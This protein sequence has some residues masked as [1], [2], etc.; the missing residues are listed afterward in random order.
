MGYVGC[1]SPGSLEVR[2]RLIHGV[3]VGNA[4]T[5]DPRVAV[6]IGFPG[7]RSGFLGRNG[8]LRIQVLEQ[9][10]GEHRHRTDDHSVRAEFLHFH[11]F[12]IHW[13]NIGKSPTPVT[14][15]PSCDWCAAAIS[16]GSMPSTSSLTRQYFYLT[17]IGSTRSPRSIIC[18]S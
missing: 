9:G 7:N 13:L 14:A 5:A 8:I 3:A 6:N 1:T 16:C 10:R 2:I 12:S 4:V 15:I 17:V 18:P 11:R